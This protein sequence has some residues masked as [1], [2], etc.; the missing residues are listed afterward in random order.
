[1]KEC[2]NNDTIITARN[3]HMKKQNNMT[4]AYRPLEKYSQRNASVHTRVDAI[5]QCKHFHALTINHLHQTTQRI[6][7]RNDKNG[8]SLF[9]FFADA[10]LPQRTSSLHTIHERFGQWYLILR[11]IFVPSIVT[12][13]VRIVPLHWRRTCPERIPPSLNDLRP[14]HL[15]GIHL[16]QSRQRTV[17]P[18]VQSPTLVHGKVRRLERIQDGPRR[19][20]GAFETGGVDYVG[21]VSLGE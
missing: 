18:L 15:R 13:I 19:L 16:L 12:G 7:M 3:I 4:Q 17:I 9:Y 5:V 20:H 8:I 6:R 11:Q 21:F 2:K 1:M 14:Q 10:V